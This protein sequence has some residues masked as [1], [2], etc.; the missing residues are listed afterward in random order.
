MEAD[1]P[2]PHLARQKKTHLKR[3]VFDVFYNGKIIPP[4]QIRIVFART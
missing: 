2:A 1:W 4:F 3:C